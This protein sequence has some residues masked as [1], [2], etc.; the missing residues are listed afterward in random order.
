M[1]AVG[2]LA[3]LLGIYSIVLVV[4]NLLSL[5]IVEAELACVYVV[6]GCSP[7][8]TLD[9]LVSHLLTADII[10]CCLS[11]RVKHW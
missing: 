5:F 9:W 6:A 1:V 8:D 11:I 3:C 2:D 7:S 10:A 4:D